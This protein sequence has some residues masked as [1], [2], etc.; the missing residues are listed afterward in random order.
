MS[1]SAESSIREW[2]MRERLA[3]WIKTAAPS[4]ASGAASPEEVLDALLDVMQS[5]PDGALVY[6]AGRAELPSRSAAEAK[7]VFTAMVEAIKAGA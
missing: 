1:A 6:E 4:V 5:A 3:R 7:A 2:A